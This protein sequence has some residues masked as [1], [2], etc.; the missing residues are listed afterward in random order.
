MIC[1]WATDCERCG[2]HVEEGDDIYFATGH[3]G[4]REK[5]C[6]MCAFMNGLVCTC[7]SAKKQGYPTCYDCKIEREEAEGL[8]C[9]CGTYKKP[10][11]ETC[12]TC[13]MEGDTE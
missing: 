10:E 6:W 12:Y 2:G 9:A 11:Y 4:R 3:L 5:I 1:N 7:G 8:R 13:K